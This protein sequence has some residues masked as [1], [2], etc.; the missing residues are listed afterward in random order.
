MAQHA[1]TLGGDRGEAAGDLGASD[2]PQGRVIGL[3]DDRLADAHHL[4]DDAG[5]EIQARREVEVA[6][7]G[8]G[9]ALDATVL[10]TA[11]GVDRTVEGNVR[12]FVA[13]D[14][15]ARRIH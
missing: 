11:I 8:A 7:G 9:E 4:G 6:V 3:L 13:R 15:L 5:L 10:A 12:R 2:A 1:V 14:D